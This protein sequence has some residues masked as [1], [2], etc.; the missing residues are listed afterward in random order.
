MITAGARSVVVVDGDG[1]PRGV[2]T[3]D[4]LAELEP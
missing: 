1:E 2:V 4:V 3:L